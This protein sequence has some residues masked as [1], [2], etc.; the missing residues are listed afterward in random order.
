[1]DP[2]KK[3]S[4]GGARSVGT[5][6]IPFNPEWYS[7]GYN[8]RMTAVDLRGGATGNHELNST[9]QC[10]DW[11]LFVTEA[12]EVSLLIGDIYDAS[13]DPALWS[14]AFEKASQYIGGSAASLTSQDL[15][16]KKSNLYFSSGHDP[17]FLRR[18]LEQYG[19]INPLFPTAYFF[20]IEKRLAVSDCLPLAEFCRTR[21]AVEWVVPQGI[22]DTMLANLEKSPATCAVFT[23]M[24][25]ARNGVANDKARHRFGLIVPHVRRALLIGNVIERHRVEAA[26]LADTL[27]TLVSGMFIVSGTGR[28]IHANASGYAMVAAANV[29]RAP[30]GR[31]TATDQTADQALLDIFTTA[32]S[33]DTALG[34]RGVAVPLKARDDERYVAHVL[35]L[36]SGARR[37]AGISY[38]AVAAIFV[39]KAALD[40]PS[41]PIVIAQ[42]FQLTRAELRVLF[43]I[44]EMDA[45]SEVAQ[46]LGITEA[47]VRTHLHRLFEKTRTGRQADLVKLV[48]GYCAAP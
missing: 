26:A 14:V 40:L 30:G 12:E 20:D 29:L 37:K 46:V 10:A 23:V 47:T 41:P 21:F 27:D 11:E 33:G 24:F 15:V 31:L 32:E 2:G 5:E 9:C 39:R 25:H 34:R 36:T 43:S 48:A 6:A 38:G 42:E 18:Y 4:N 13:L 7:L 3:P 16:G 45:V 19:R 22:V 35:P 28:I 1:M 8:K 17:D 44:I